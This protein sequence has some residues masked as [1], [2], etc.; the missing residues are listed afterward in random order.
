MTE[1]TEG[2]QELE[3]QAL[4]VP[5]QAK[6]ITITD[7]A[8]YERAGQIL[9]IVKGLRKKIDETFDPIISKAFAAHK[10][11]KA[12]KT[13]VEAPLLVAE[14]HVK[15][16]MAFY[17]NEQERKR[18]EEEEKLRLEAQ[19]KAEAEQLAR[20]EAAE[21][22][23]NHQAAEA[24]ISAPV[25]V[26]PVV[27]QS[28]TPKVAGVSYR[29]SWKFRITDP[30]LVPREY[31]IPDDK[32]IGAVVRALKDQCKISGVEVYSEDTVSAGAAY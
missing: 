31:L 14:A 8:S 4:S 7:Q 25:Q 2:V 12:Q 18:R 5:D 24:I 28:E 1:Q 19:K 16:L 30:A 3:V 9:V 27:L 29:K 11:A 21:K 23:G 6:Q 32:A 13:K 15:P 17:V 10:E 26:A 22:Q 20:A